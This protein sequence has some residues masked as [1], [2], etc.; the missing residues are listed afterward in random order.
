M[1]PG[2]GGCT[3]PHCGYVE[4]VKCP[5]PPQK[6]K[7]NNTAMVSQVILS[8]RK[9]AERV[10]EVQNAPCPPPHKTHPIHRRGPPGRP[11]G[12]CPR[13]AG[14]GSGGYTH[15]AFDCRR[16]HTPCSSH[17]CASPAPPAAA[18]SPGL[19]TPVTWLPRPCPGG[20]K[21]PLNFALS[22]KVKTH[23]C[24]ITHFHHSAL[25]DKVKRQHCFITLLCLTKSKDNPVASLCFV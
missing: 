14:G 8:S 19:S 20:H 21:L 24:F 10:E 3:T 6:K 17:P 13:W 5:T 16:A 9:Q 2:S 22:D 1:L 25:S 18:T 4:E 15:P 7:H 12:S 11:P 23:H